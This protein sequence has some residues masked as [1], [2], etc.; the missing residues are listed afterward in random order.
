VS[1]AGVC[2]RTIKQVR[3]AAESFG[4]SAVAYLKASLELGIDKGSA[5]IWQSDLR[6]PEKCG[7]RGV[8]AVRYIAKPTILAALFSYRRAA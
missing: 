2:H 1:H 7:S 8:A 3:I 4:G 5:E 6:G